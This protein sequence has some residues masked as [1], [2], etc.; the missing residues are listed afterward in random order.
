[1][2]KCSSVKPDQ[3]PSSGHFSEWVYH[4]FDYSFYYQNIK[5]NAN[6]RIEKYFKL[7]SNQ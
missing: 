2:V 1:M 3:L 4:S 5:A 6:E 7:N